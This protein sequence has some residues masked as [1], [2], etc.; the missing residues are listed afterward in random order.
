MKLKVLVQ[1]AGALWFG[2]ADDVKCDLSVTL[3]HCQQSLS[4]L[5]ASPAAGIWPVV[6]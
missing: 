2:T 4:P 1:R 6:W 5:D 3:T